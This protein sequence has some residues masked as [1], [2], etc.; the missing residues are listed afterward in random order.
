MEKLWHRPKY[1]L[2][3]PNRALLHSILYL[4]RNNVPVYLNF[5]HKARPFELTMSSSLT[6]LRYIQVVQRRRLAD[7]V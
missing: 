1:I 6:D 7:G 3:R 5:S 2:A 4:R